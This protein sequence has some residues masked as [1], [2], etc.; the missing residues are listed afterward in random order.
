MCLGIW[1]RV[2]L[3]LFGVF[4]DG[5]WVFHQTQ[6]GQ[7]IMFARAGKKHQMGQND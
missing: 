4:W 7:I 1:F 5:L 6:K 2:V 3:V